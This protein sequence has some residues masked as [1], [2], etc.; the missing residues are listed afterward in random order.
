MLYV[1][2]YPFAW[3]DLSLHLY[4]LLC[5]LP[6][7]FVFLFHFLPSPLPSFTPLLS[8]TPSPPFPS[9][10]PPFPSPSPPFLSPPLPISP[11]SHPSSL[12]LPP[13]ASSS[14]KPNSLR[15]HTVLQEQ[16]IASIGAHGQTFAA[17][18]TEGSLFLIGKT[19]KG[20]VD[21]DTGGRGACRQGCRWAWLI[22]RG[23]HNPHEVD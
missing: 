11:P 20:L 3:L 1:P 10:S 19:F 4:P 5:L 6:L 14:S 21:K 23:C 7:L 12:S 2:C 22:V 17:V 8:L 9:P 15:K 18:N 13:S 16:K